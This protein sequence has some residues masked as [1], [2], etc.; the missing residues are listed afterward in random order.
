MDR[1]VVIHVESDREVRV[2]SYETWW[3]VPVSE[4]SDVESVREAR[5]GYEESRTAQRWHL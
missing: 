4:V 2:G 1:T 5:R 3:D